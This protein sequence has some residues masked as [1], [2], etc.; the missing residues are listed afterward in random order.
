MWKVSEQIGERAYVVVVG[1]GE[2][3][4]LH[5]LACDRL[6]FGELGLVFFLG[7]QPGI[8]YDARFFGA[9]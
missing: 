8:D 5:G 9:D 2:Y 4:A 7:V 6:V 3:D 1:M